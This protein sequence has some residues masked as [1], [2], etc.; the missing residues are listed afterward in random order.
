MVCNHSRL[1][2]I[3]TIVISSSIIGPPVPAA[4]FDADGIADAG[5]VELL[6]GTPAGLDRRS[7]VDDLW[8]QDRD[9][10]FGAAEA[11]DQFGY[12]IAAGDFDGDT[13]ADLAVASPP[14]RTR[15]GIR[16]HRESKEHPSPSIISGGLSPPSRRRRCSS[17]TASRAATPGGGRPRAP[18]SLNSSAWDEARRPLRWR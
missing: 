2:I 12:A 5:A 6:Y 14:P 4:D 16:T 1:V 15:C 9:N 8:H 3:G 17:A 10:V 7:G 13:F 18:E 11:E